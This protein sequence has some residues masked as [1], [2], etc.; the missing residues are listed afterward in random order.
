MDGSAVW[1][2]FL[3]PVEVNLPKLD[4]S[5]LAA[6]EGAN[7]HILRAQATISKHSRVLMQSN[8]RFFNPDPSL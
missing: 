6:L 1:L 7:F 4:A 8:T 3:K 2:G 5:W